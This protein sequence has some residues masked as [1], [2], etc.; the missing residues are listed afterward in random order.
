MLEKL[1][2]L[3]PNL[4]FYDV[5]DEAFRPYGRVIEDLDTDE[6]VKAGNKI[7]LPTSGASYVPSEESFEVLPIAKEITDKC[8]GTL[9][10]QIGFCWGHNTKMEA[11]EW[12]TSSEV[13]I[14]TKP[15]VLLLGLRSDLVNNRI[16]SATFKAFYV[17]T[18]VAVEVFATSLHYCACQVSDEGFGCVVGL[19]KDTNTDLPKGIKKGLMFA[20][21]K[22]LIA[23]DDN[24]SLI[25][26]GAVAGIFGENYDIKY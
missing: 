26:D 14:A 22:W 24:V 7:S 17:P 2:K 20:R 21:N 23:H 15:I 11:T 6:I 5:Y 12:H 8:F 18:G 16:D 19:P 25:A 4:A 9:P 10:T 3:N 13:N 1:K